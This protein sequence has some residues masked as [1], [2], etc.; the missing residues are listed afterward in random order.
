VNQ[1][2]HLGDI[3][4]GLRGRA[5]EP[6]A[7]QGPRLVLKDLSAPVGEVRARRAMPEQGTEA[8]GDIAL[9][10][11]ERADRRKIVLTIGICD[12]RHGHAPIV[13]VKVDSGC[14]PGSGGPDELACPKRNVD[15][16]GAVLVKAP[17]TD[18]VRLGARVEGDPAKG[19]GQARHMREEDGDLSTW[20]EVHVVVDVA[21]L[22][23]GRLHLPPDPEGSQVPR[24]VE[25]DDLGRAAVVGTPPDNDEVDVLAWKGI[26][27]AERHD[28][29]NFVD[30]DRR[31]RKER[32]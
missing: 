26:G 11:V 18:G 1:R 14:R 20:G 5:V 3:P 30:R 31:Y 12:V 24:C 17:V 23:I 2:R 9:V 16:S 19:A 25:V 28:V 8:R 13:D 15:L 27:A 10:V 21:G 29:R 32:T 4:V 22:S 7:L 6:V